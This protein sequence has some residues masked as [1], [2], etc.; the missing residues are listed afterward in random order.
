MMA[1]P[2]ARSSPCGCAERS[3][4]EPVNGGPAGFLAIRLA[5]LDATGHAGPSA[6]RRGDQSARSP[7][8]TTSPAALSRGQLVALALSATFPLLSSDRSCAPVPVG[9]AG[10]LAQPG[11]EH[12]GG[13]V[14]GSFGNSCRHKSWCL[15]GP[16]RG[17]RFR[18]AGGWWVAPQ[19][20][21]TPCGCHYRLDNC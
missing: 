13:C 11:A 8:E 15:L 16:L 17:W 6:A 3:D 18:S 14:H 5:V 20:C 7:V 1:R 21:S 4:R 10:K 12:I 9:V 2:S 19:L